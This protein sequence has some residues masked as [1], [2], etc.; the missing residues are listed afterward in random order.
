MS[1]LSNIIYYFFLFVVFFCGLLFF[2][3][4]YDVVHI[5]FEKSIETGKTTFLISFK[6]DKFWD[7]FYKFLD[8]LVLNIYLIE[9]EYDIDIFKVINYFIAF[10]NFLFKIFYVIL[11]IFSSPL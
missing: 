3:N 11:Y 9:L 10:F 1:K 6:F 7:D 5:V 4:Y 2:F 8:Y